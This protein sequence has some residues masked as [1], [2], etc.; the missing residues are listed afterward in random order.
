MLDVRKMKKIARL[1][2]FCSLLFAISCQK[3]TTF[4]ISETSVGPLSH[5]NTFNDLETVFAQDSIVKDTFRLKQ[6]ELPRKVKVFEKGG[7]LLLTLTPSS[8]SIPKIENIRIEDARYLTE[9]GVGLNSTFA[10]IQK[11]YEIKKLVTTLQSIV[12]FPK[13][14]NLYFTIDKEE[15][16]GSVRYSMGDIEAVQIPDDAKIKYLMIGWSD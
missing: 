13:N 3:E 12:V 4:L 7:K 9:K 5:T 2:V 10:S 14:S 8:D 11:N 1:I 15:L 16:P 6:G